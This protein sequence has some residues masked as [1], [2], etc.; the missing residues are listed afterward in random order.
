MSY[1]LS[2]R[3]KA[4]GTFYM[5]GAYDMAFHSRADGIMG[6][7]YEFDSEG[8]ANVYLNKYRNMPESEEYEL[9]VSEYGR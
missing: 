2:A 7:P 1:I 5:L 9:E 3:S 4:T 6:I 8:M